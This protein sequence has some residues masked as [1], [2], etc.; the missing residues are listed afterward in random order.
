[1]RAR[2]WKLMLDV[3]YLDV[4]GYLR[5]V[6]LGPSEVSHKSES[7]R[8]AAVKGLTFSVKNDTFRTLATD[9]QFKGKVKEDMLIRLLEAFVWKNHCQLSLTSD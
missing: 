2:I 1:M 7:Y 9:T 5:C 8:L 3:N 4:D 6:A